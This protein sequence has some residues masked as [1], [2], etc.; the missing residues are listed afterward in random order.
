MAARAKPTAQAKAAA[1]A[2]ASARA[3]SA[4]QAR[5]STPAPS[6]PST[7]SRPPAKA[8]AP[9]QDSLPPEQTAAAAGTAL[10]AAPKALL[11]AAAAQ[12]IEAVGLAA[13]AVL[14]AISTADGHSHTR[15]SGIAITVLV[16]LVA[17]GLAAVA[18]SL[19]KAR[20]WSRVPSA[21]TQVFIIIV[22]IALIGSHPGWAGP[23]LA[24]A[25]ICLAGLLTP[26]SLRALNRSLDEPPVKSR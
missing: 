11:V 6:R 14:S 22:G 20:P 3:K 8:S 13:L 10:A 12:G 23:A 18:V 5:S 25:V 9:A 15:A 21:L 26:A 17:A 16:L 1:K 4:A 2:K 24:V 19:A 7:P